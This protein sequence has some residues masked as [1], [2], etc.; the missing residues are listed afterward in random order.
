MTRLSSSQIRA[1]ESIITW[2][3]YVKHETHYLILQTVRTNL[4]R[5]QMLLNT[6]KRFWISILKRFS[7]WKINHN[8]HLANNNA[9]EYN[10]FAG[11][12]W[13]CIRALILA[14]VC[15]NEILILHSKNVS[16]DSWSMN[17]DTVEWTIVNE[18]QMIDG[19]HFMPPRKKV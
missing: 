16:V 10:F 2:W 13:L 6:S 12:T 17:T 19:S 18:R 11:K 5:R 9:T 7:N 1:R 4:T 15:V 8:G 14:H 3:I